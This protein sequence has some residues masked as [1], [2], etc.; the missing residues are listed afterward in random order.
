MRR[1]HAC[2]R[3]VGNLTP[4]T[5]GVTTRGRAPG[6]LHLD[7]GEEGLEGVRVPRRGGRGY[8]RGVKKWMPQRLDGVW[9]V[10]TGA[11]DWVAA[12]TGAAL[13]AITGAV[14]VIVLIVVFW[15]WLSD[16]ESGSTTIRNV[17]LVVG[18]AIALWIAVWRS[19]IAERQADTAQQDLRNKR[20]QESAGMLGSD[21]LAARLA[22]IYALQ[23]LAQ[24][25]P[26][27]HH[28]EV[29][30]LLCAFVR[31]PT[32]DA[33]LEADEVREDVQVA[34]DAIGACHERQLLL[35]A[36]EK[37]WLDLHGA[38]LREAKL[39]GRN[40]SSASWPDPDIKLSSMAE[41]F[42]F[43]RGPDFS[44]AKL[45]LAQLQ[46]AK[47]QRADFTEA[48]LQHANYTGA[49]LSEARFSDADLKHALLSGAVLSGAAFSTAT[50]LTQE[51]L[52]HAIADPQNPP[53]LEGV[54]DEETGEQLVWRGEGLDAH[55]FYRQDSDD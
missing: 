29:M 36:G 28:I 54:L 13:G 22:G 47:L 48:K 26:W 51:Q 3:G 33:A 9:S 7:D 15:D 10:V 8:G 55:P 40:F 18:G 14:I 24:D 39:M 2:E 23:R 17:G 4:L 11:C 37:F 35:E 32:A 30:K 52:D 43:R 49:D 34:I 19:R 31:N 42:T 21:V 12:R 45:Q 27:E 1:A 20:H 38:D 46:L 44:E 6:A 41:L 50:N 25:H 16:G 53:K 5:P